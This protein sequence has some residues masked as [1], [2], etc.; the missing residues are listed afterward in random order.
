MKTERSSKRGTSF[1]IPIT[2]TCTGGTLVTSL[3]LPSLVTVATVPVSATPKLAPVMPMSAVR[4]FSR[5]RLRAKEPRASTSGR[6]SRTALRPTADLWVKSSM[7]SWSCSSATALRALSLKPSTPLLMP[8][9]RR[10]FVSRS[11]DGFRVSKISTSL[12]VIEHLGEVEHA[13]VVALAPQAAFQVHQATGVAGDQDVSAALFQRL[14]L[15]VRHRGGHVGHLHRK[16]SPE[17]ATQLLVLPLHKVESLHVPEKP[18]RLVEY[19]ELAPLVTAA[20]EDGFPLQACPE[21]LHAHHVDQ[22]VRELPHAPSEGFG[23]LALLR[24][25]LEDEGVVMGDHGG[26]RSRR[27][28]HVVE[29]LPLEN[30]KEVASHSAG[31]VEEAGVEG[32]LAAAGLAFR[33]G[34]VDAEPAQHA[35]HAY[36]YLRPDQVNVTRH[37]QSHPQRPDPLSSNLPNARPVYQRNYRDTHRPGFATDIPS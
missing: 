27:T 29:A 23:T 15:L 24:Q 30:V 12:S 21:V 36:A 37:E 20:V 25:I 14:Y 22:E 17:P 33:I 2:T 28:Y 1:S 16:R 3:A 13:G 31:F 5:R 19:A 26:A 7:E 34:Y 9:S 6:A 10:S 18:V 4:N 11:R 8:S 35:H 32:G